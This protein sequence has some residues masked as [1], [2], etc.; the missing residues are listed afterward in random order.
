MYMILAALSDLVKM[1]STDDGYIYT[2]F[3][4]LLSMGMTVIAISMPFK[5]LKS[6]NKIE[7]KIQ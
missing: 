3:A 5:Y 4:L 7:A 1:T 6:V 2:I